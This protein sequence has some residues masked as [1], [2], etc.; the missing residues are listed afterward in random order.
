[1]FRLCL[2][3]VLACH[4]VAQTFTPVKPHSYPLAVRNPY[5][6]AWLPGPDAAA[7]PAAS[8]QF[9]FGNDLTWSV[10][11]R[12]DDTTYNLFGVLEN[13][14]GAQSASLVSAEY[15]ATHTIFTLSAGDSA[16]FRLD[17]F[18]PISAKDLVSQSLPFSYLTVF[19]SGANGNTPHVSVYSDIDDTWTGQNTS[20]TSNH[21]TSGSTSVYSLSA[22][23]GALY[24][25]SPNEMALWGT[26]IYATQSSTSSRVSTRSG[27][28]SEV[29][30][31][32][33]SRGSLRQRHPEWAG[34]NVAG[35]S[36]DLGTVGAETS[37]TFAVGYVRDAAINYLGAAQTE[38]WRS[39][40][41]DEVAAVVAFLDGYGDAQT[42]SENL[43]SDIKTKSANA[44]GSNYSDITTLTVRQAFGA[45]DITI[46]QDTKDTGDA[47]IFMKEISSDGNVN[48]MDVI[49]PAHPIF[50]TFDAEYIRMLLEP[51]V[52]Y[53][54]SGAWPLNYTVHDIGAAYPNATGHND[55]NAEVMPIE[56]CGNL[57]ILA[58]TYQKLSGNT[59]WA[60]QYA[61]IFRQYA[62]YL[63]QHGLYTAMQLS[64]DD[65]AGP[66]ANQTNL[67][68]KA[69]VAL[70][71]YGKMTG[72]TNY[73]DAGLDFSKTLYDQAV[74]TDADK[75]HF[76][77]T[78]DNTSSW[79]TTFNLFPDKLLDLGTFSDDAYD[80][81][82]T[83]YPSVREEA[84]VPLD[85]R[86]DWAKTDW[87]IFSAAIASAEVSDLF[88]NDLH[89][90]LAGGPT[91]NNE[92]FSD[93]YFVSPKDGD[94]VDAYDGFRARPVVGGHFAIL[95]LNGA[96]F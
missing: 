51:V 2:A 92:P 8:P 64:T 3:A 43:D 23:D 29:R 89:Q 12:V 7:I 57:L 4:V 61:G 16:S 84:G 24:S 10:M 81:Q 28:R 27:P 67:A 17:F 34:G 48:T 14:H 5:L 45:I 20:T 47:K 93:K 19:A 18:S 44:A 71:A 56:E 32:F 35:F 13:T 1:M 50:Y 60:T 78:Y 37:A 66:A 58:Y 59:D 88:I 74:G 72:Q 25:Q 39:K 21:T 55:G 77:L 53:L 49:F 69:A 42:S 87:N 73:S 40:Y 38:Y 22:T 63:N 33:A 85:S 94:V 15:T 6:S 76:T 62:D 52:Q 82:N 65:G 31:D 90:F 86:L 91:T 46:P 11:A 9:W 96:S 70:S 30:E 75:T 41:T 83:F 68:I 95:A 54:N 36:H 79:T 80:M 26:A